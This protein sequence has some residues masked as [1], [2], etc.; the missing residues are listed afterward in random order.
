M[1]KELFAWIN[2]EEDAME[3]G[4]IAVTLTKHQGEIVGI[5]RTINIKD[6]YSK[7]KKDANNPQKGEK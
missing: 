7:A 3:Y 1:L 6:H 2:V 5:E 4:T